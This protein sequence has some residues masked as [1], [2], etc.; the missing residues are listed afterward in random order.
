MNRCFV[1]LEWT[2]QSAGGAGAQRLPEHLS[3]VQ[4]GGARRRY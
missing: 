4:F 1:T 2:A 3:S